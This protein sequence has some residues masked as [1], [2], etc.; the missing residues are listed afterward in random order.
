MRKYPKLPDIFDE[1]LDILDSLFEETPPDG[2]TPAADP[3]DIVDVVSSGA[4]NAPVDLPPAAQS[5]AGG[6]QQSDGEIELANAI[7]MPGGLDHDHDGHDEEDDM[8]D[9][10]SGGK[11][12]TATTPGFEY[13]NVGPPSGKGP[14]RGGDSGDDGTGGGDD[15]NTLYATYTSGQA[16]ANGFDFFNIHIQFYGTWQAQFMEAFAAAADFLSSI[17]EQ[18][19]EDDPA[20]FNTFSSTLFTV[21][22]VLIEARL[23]AIDGENGILGRAGAYSVREGG[24]VDEYT[25]VV[26]VMEFD[27]ADAQNLL[28]DKTW[29]DTIL[30]EMIHV[31]GF[32]TLW[33]N[34]GRDLVTV[35]ETVDWISGENTRSPRDDVF[36]VTTTAVYD[37]VAGNAE[38]TAETGNTGPLVVETDG[39]SG[40]ALSHWD[41]IEYDGELM[42]GYLNNNPSE[43]YLSDWSLLAL[44]DIGYDVISDFEGAGVQNELADGVDLE[45]ATAEMAF[46]DADGFVLV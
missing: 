30:H 23:P 6:D 28:D 2:E 32:G 33:D 8:S 19:L 3:V 34:F 41:E 9:A 45:L 43:I 46:Y 40:T 15:S 13:S 11:T 5:R 4:Q 14:N 44:E 20:S 22:D 21:D 35:T 42:T 26:G 39:G 16:D 18:G 37:G 27:V 31:L 17:M 1:P 10:W 24:T 29:D 36:E 12:A 25:T 7:L 38:Y